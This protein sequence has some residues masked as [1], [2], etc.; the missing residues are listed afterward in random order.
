MGDEII[1]VI[2][3]ETPQNRHFADVCQIMADWLRR[4]DQEACFD[5]FVGVCGFDWEAQ[6]VDAFLHTF[7]SIV[8]MANPDPEWW[9]KQRDVYLARM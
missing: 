6:H 8:A 1:A 4:D 2:I 7:G 5:Y 9:L 3:H